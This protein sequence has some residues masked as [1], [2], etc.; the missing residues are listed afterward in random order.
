MSRL[1]TVWI[2]I[3]LIA[4]LWAPGS[5]RAEM[6]ATVWP[7]AYRPIPIQGGGPMQPF[8]VAGSS[9]LSVAY[10]WPMPF[11]FKFNGLEYQLINVG[12]KG[13]VSFH[14]STSDGYTAT[15]AAGRLLVSGYP[16]RVV[17]AWWGDHTCALG[18]SALSNQTLGRAPNRIWVIQWGCSLRK[19][20]AGS[21]PTNT[22]FQAQ[23]WFYEGSN[24][25]QARYGDIVVGDDRS[26]QQDPGEEGEW[27]YVSWGV[28]LANEPGRLGPTREGERDACLP[29]GATAPPCRSHHFPFRSTIQYGFFPGAHPVLGGVEGSFEAVGAALQLGMRAVV[30]NGGEAPA[31]VPYE[32]YLSNT[33]SFTVDAPGNFLVES[34]SFPL[35]GAAGGE[36]GRRELVGERLATPPPG[37]YHLCVVL[38]PAAGTAHLTDGGSGCSE[39][40][41]SWGPDLGGAISETPLVGKAGD[42]IGLQISLENFGSGPAPGFGYRIEA[43]P[44]ELPVGSIPAQ[45]VTLWSGRVD[46]LPA[47]GEPGAAIGLRFDGSE[48]PLL[49]LPSLLRG[50]RYSFE[51]VIDSARESGDVNLANNRAT[52]AEKMSTLKPRLSIQPNSIRLELPEGE[53]I[54]GEPVE[55]T[56]EICNEGPLE[57]VGFSPGALIGWYQRVS[58]QEDPAA[59]T[60]PQS[61]HAPS[62]PNHLI[63]ESVGGH[64]AS[65]VASLCRVHCSADADCASPLRCLA[66]PALAAASGDS[67]AK[68]CRNYLAGADE[69]GAVS[70]QRYQV[71]GEIPAFDLASMP[72]PPGEQRFHFVTDTQRSLSEALP[73]VV[74]TEPIFCQDPIADL[75][76]L[77]MSPP[78]EVIAGDVFSVSRSIR[79]LG[80]VERG[81]D[82]KVQPFLSFR[83]RYYLAPLDAEIS[84]A[85]IPL[86]LQATGGAGVATVG[87]KGENHL[88]DVVTV[89]SWLLP[90]EYRIGLILDPQG[91]LREW[92]KDNNVFTFPGV[93]RV[94]EGSLRLTSKVLPAATK[95]GLYTF[96]LQALGGDAAYAWTGAE[97]PPGFELSREG[98][99]VGVPEEAGTFAFGVRL[100]SGSRALQERLALQVLEHAADLDIATRLL[101]PARKG[102]RYGGW[103]D[104]QGRAQQGVPLAASGGFPP[105]RWE[106]V[107][108]E[109]GHRL[110]QGLVLNGSTGVIG[111]EPSALARSSSFVARVRDSRG[112]AAIRELELVVVGET[113]LAITSRL[114]AQGLTSQPYESCIEA[115]GGDASSPYVWEVDEGS[116][117]PGLSLEARGREA[118]LLGVPSSCGIFMVGASVSD[119]AGERFSTSLPLIVD[120]DRIQVHTRFFHPFQRRETVEVHLVS[121]A[122]RGARFSI[123]QGRLPPGLSLSAEGL[124]SGVIAEN[125]AFG[126]NDFVVEVRDEEGREGLTALTI[127]VGAIAR[128]ALQEERETSGCSS[129]GGAGDALF[130]GLALLAFS[131][132]RRERRVVRG[133]GR[134]LSFAAA[135]VLFG[136]IG[137]SE[138]ETIVHGLCHQVECGENTEC[139]PGDG[140]CK[141]GGPDG[142]FCRD[143]EVC[144]SEPSP[145]CATSRCD[146][147][148]CEG[149][150][151]CD[152]RTGA[153]T[154]GDAVCG[155]GEQ[156]VD[157]SCV[158]DRRCEGTICNEG[159]RCDPQDGHCKC[160]GVVCG[161]KESCVEGSCLEDLCKGVN[162]SLHSVC[163]PSDGSCH[164]A[165]IAGP[166][167]E[168]GEACGLIQELSGSDEGEAP[169]FACLMDELC[170]EDSCSG[171]SVCDPSDGL[172]RCG[173]L[174]KLAPTCAPGQSC[175]DGACRGGDLCAP[176]G[177]VTVCGDGLSCDPVDGVCKCGGVDGEACGAVEVCVAVEGRPSCEASCTIVIGVDESCGSG[178]SCYLDRALPHGVPF[179]AAV[180]PMGVNDA[181]DEFN[182]CAA[183]L[184]CSRANVCRRLCHPSE[185]AGV[186]CGDEVNYRCLPFTES[187]SQQRDLGYCTPSFG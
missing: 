185:G 11:P 38:D 50:N 51:L 64:D 73:H 149:G 174:G 3:S 8:S 49:R 138:T 92:R 151:S 117:P 124:V 60:L 19:G 6:P 27:P 30:N 145:H 7:S 69:S 77:G 156:C 135:A 162:C 141:C 54:Y 100:Q 23:L 70:C 83:Y 105:Y 29:G 175:I 84:T 136:A 172:C 41:F 58:F 1:F 122:G 146:F 133:G 53:C 17:A 16:Q 62:S 37:R 98:L 61:C 45:I 187:E 85:Q 110:P 171:G 79:N 2:A 139:D 71:W 118:C 147:V 4:S 47:A 108:L 99:L 154:C 116:L 121:N 44:D 72:L 78:E 95:G 178:R 18:T 5:A 86:D 59:A 109:P 34:G 97:L 52:S 55:A 131:W 186:G 126:T 42:E 181:C 66:D 111:G 180:G 140:L 28:K 183:G 165:S 68:S 12:Q 76:V 63:C 40:A 35:P 74:S 96:Q 134:L 168:N 155:E 26:W 161:A 153:C 120:C 142:A 32:V 57:A 170:R 104:G 39:A 101:P 166:I 13:Y 67:A 160:D 184:F 10:Q 115:A 179:C 102:H 94:R 127:T 21:E 128:E 103:I 107:A 106:L 173:E 177:V 65:C 169:I 15:T 157:R 80:H 36:A 14:P 81:D 167:C 152:E 75:T 88:V 176:G 22:Y 130:G 82:G 56:L 31:E 93:V 137:C 90:G 159:M 158:A 123:Q 150:H 43:V 87:R 20:A 144:V 119:V 182:D 112:N 9:N 46:G 48:L 91:E 129:A 25:I 89:P 114:F 164:C 125:A 163:D 24:V 143:G 148:I 33:G 113:E 132:W